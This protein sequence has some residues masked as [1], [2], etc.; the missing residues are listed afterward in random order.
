MDREWFAV[1]V[2]FS[3]LI[4]TVASHGLE[5]ILPHD[6]AGMCSFY[7]DS[8]IL[9]LYVD[10]LAAERVF[11]IHCYVQD[12]DSWRFATLQTWLKGF[13]GFSVFLT[14]ECSQN[15]IISLPWPM[16]AK[17]LVGMKVSNCRLQDKYADVTNP[18]VTGL[19]DQLRVLDLRDSVW[20]G[21]DAAFEF[22]TRSDVL[23][24]IGADYDCGQDST[25]EYM[26]ISNVTD[27][28]NDGPQF[29]SDHNYYFD[30]GHSKTAPTSAGRAQ[31][32]APYS[33]PSETQPKPSISTSTNSSTTMASL[34]LE[35]KLNLLLQKL[36]KVANISEPASLRVGKP[37]PGSMNSTAAASQ[38]GYEDL[39][40][41]IQSVQHTCVYERL[42][43]LDESSP[44]VMPVHHFSIMVQGGSYPELRTMNYS[45]SG[46]QEI[47]TELTQFRMFFPKLSYL[48]L[49]KNMIRHVTLAESA[50]PGRSEYL[51]LDLRLN[52]I[53]HIN[54][55]VV[56]SWADTQDIFVDI[57]FNP[58]HCGCHMVDLLHKMRKANF[59]TDSMA[60]YEYLKDVRCHT[61]PHLTGQRLGTVE[62]SCSGRLMEASATK[63]T[64]DASLSTT[65]LAV[66][67]AFCGLA[68]IIL[69]I[70]GVVAVLYLSRF[71][72][73]NV[74]QGIKPGTIQISH[75][76]IQDSHCSTQDSHSSTQDSHSST[77]ASL[78]STQNSHSST[79]DSHFST[80][81]SHSSTQ[82]SHFSTQDSHAS[83]RCSHSP[84]VELGLQTELVS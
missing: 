6:W 22:M 24:T 63:L 30:I 4:N 57:R 49:T 47:P 40:E 82:D 36:S 50:E 74:K 1:F 61:P 17:G 42:R 48:D 39:L 75:F 23:L 32:I 5:T 43:V 44:S 19:P 2:V 46:L 81:D 35:T 31:T 11:S 77:Q 21:D 37:S 28:L 8:N 64:D 18:D 67:L 20:L 69:V 76:S 45:L 84:D 73:L 10:H 14:V 38:A 29:G 16:K 83:T 68:V 80:Q 13:T 66:L 52:Y 56:W 70:V 33:Q 34:D 53:T 65:N 25:L 3:L 9:G 78:S 71:G 55:N 62:L 60:K 79:Q 59:F 15:G 41:N 58:L 7:Q 72:T 54:L 26:V 51:T 27:L 12:S